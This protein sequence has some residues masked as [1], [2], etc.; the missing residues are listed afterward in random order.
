MLDHAYANPGRAGHACADHE[1]QVSLV[2]QCHAA[3]SREQYVHRVGR[4]GRASASGRCTL[5]LNNPERKIL[6]SQL[7]GLPLTAA[8]SQSGWLDEARP[9]VNDTCK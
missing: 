8:V 2:I 6:S 1:W 9:M 3:S 7:G 4:T 5:L